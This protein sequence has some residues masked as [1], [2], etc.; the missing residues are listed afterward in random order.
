[1]KTIEI[2][3]SIQGE[4]K[5]MGIPQVFIRLAGCNLSCSWCD[6]PQSKGGGKEMSVETVVSEVEL[7]GIKSVCITGGEPLLQVDDVR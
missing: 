4:G 6:T 1:M 7:L 3:S 5:F 2:F